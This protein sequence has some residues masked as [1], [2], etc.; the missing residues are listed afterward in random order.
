MLGRI[1]GR[2]WLRRN[3]CHEFINTWIFSSYD[4]SEDVGVVGG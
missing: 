4:R 2:L 1:L 3:L